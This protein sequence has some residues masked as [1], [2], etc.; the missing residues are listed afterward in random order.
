MPIH[1]DDG[2]GGRDRKAKP[3]LLESLCDDRREARPERWL[4]PGK[5]KINPISP[6]QL[7]RAVTPAMH[8]AGI[9]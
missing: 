4:L 3:C 8:R 2:N 9:S 5:P 6:R 7:N 1:V